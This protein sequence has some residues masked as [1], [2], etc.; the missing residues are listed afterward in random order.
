MIIA[1]IN[2]KD[3]H[4]TSSDIIEHIW[5]VNVAVLKCNTYSHH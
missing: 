4:G 1:L 2:F 3:Q 5:S